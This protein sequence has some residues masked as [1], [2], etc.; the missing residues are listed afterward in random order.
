MLGDH[1]HFLS[2]HP[3]SL[4][5]MLPVYICKWFVTVDCRYTVEGLCVPVLMYCS[6]R[7]ILHLTRYFQEFRTQVYLLSAIESSTVGSQSPTR[8]LWISCNVFDN[9]LSQNLLLQPH[10]FIPSR[11]SQAEPQ[12]LLAPFQMGFGSQPG[13]IQYP[14]SY[15]SYS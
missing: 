14:N 5:H 15:E 11:F 10:W 3:L 7:S 4:T 6:L 13:E 2:A 8:E 1:T 12:A 9:A